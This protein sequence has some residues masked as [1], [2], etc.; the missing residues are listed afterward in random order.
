VEKALDVFEWMA[1][2]RGAA[3]VRF[4]RFSVFSRYG[5]LGYRGTTGQKLTAES[6]L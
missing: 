6:S 4:C 3:Q 1:E 2:G 5:D